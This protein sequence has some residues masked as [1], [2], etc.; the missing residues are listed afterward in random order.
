M[1]TYLHVKYLLFLS[2]FTQTSILLTD[3]QKISKYQFSY[4]SVQWEPSCSM[5][6]ARQNEANT[7]FLQ[8]CERT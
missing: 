4:K 5:P 2:G 1:H 6:T 8:F 7:H 3:V